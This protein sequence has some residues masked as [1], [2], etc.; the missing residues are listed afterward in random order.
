MTVDGPTAGV[1]VREATRADLIDVY[2]IEKRSFRQ[3]WPFAAFERFLDGPGFLVAVEDDAVVGYVVADLVPD[4]GRAGGHVKD[5]AVAPDAR[6]RGIASRLL[7][8][9]LARLAASDAGRVKLEVRETN[10]AARTLYRSFGFD[11]DHAVPRYYDDGEAALVMVRDVAGLEVEWARDRSV[12]QAA[13]T[14][15]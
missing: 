10:E 3:P 8:E 9:A 6:G 15:D 13:P 1:T 4:H 14:E 5:L 11:V 2:R 7:T 12:G